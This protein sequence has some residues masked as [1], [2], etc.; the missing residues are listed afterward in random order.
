M[1]PEERLSRL[2]RAVEALQV[3]SNED[4]VPIL[5]EGDKDEAALRHLGVRGPV[6]KVNAGRT[7]FVFVEE[8]ARGRRDA[9]LLVDWDRTGGRLARRLREACGANAV[10]LD[11]THRRALAEAAGGDVKTVESLD[12]LLATLRQRAQQA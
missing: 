12:T 2:E 6:V 1:S 11:E 9:I 8:Y 7:L 3:A 4:G 5:V 10:K